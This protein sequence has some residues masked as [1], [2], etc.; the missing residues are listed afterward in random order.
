MRPTGR[1]A[2]RGRTTTSNGTR[3]TCTWFRPTLRTPP[4]T[5]AGLSHGTCTSNLLG[6]DWPT[7]GKLASYRATP[8]LA[9]ARCSPTGLPRGTNFAAYPVAN[10]SASALKAREIVQTLA[11]LSGGCE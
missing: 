3:P 1:Y 10:R 2:V 7:Q 9:T 11:K 5:P 4:I 6:F 8:A